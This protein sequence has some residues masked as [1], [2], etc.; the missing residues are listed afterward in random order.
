M[1]LYVGDNHPDIS[2]RVTFTG[3]NWQ[4][5]TNASVLFTMQ[6]GVATPKIDN[7]S[8][9][10]VIDDVAKTIDWTC[11]IT[12]AD[13]DTE[14][15]YDAHVHIILDNPTKNLTSLISEKI[16]VLTHSHNT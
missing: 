5:L 13:I 16:N 4:S 6:A 10:V 8:C 2:G 15:Q 3:T 14:G 11:A 9:T 12:A 7:R 1:D